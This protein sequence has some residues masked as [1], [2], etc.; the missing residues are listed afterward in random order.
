MRL[1]LYV[2]LFHYLFFLDLANRIELSHL[3]VHLVLASLLILSYQLFVL[4]NG[5][6]N[7]LCCRIF[8]LW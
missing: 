5:F 1:F 7:G 3:S 6:G 4:Q 8:L 2:N